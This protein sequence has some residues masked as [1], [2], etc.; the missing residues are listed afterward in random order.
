ML[1]LP[2]LYQK[3]EHTDPENFRLSFPE[4]KMPRP[5]RRSSN[6]VFQCESHPL[7][8]KFSPWVRIKVVLCS[9]HTRLII[10]DPW[11]S[12]NQGNSSLVKVFPSPYTPLLKF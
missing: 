10:Y 9:D 3:R 6:P 11:K 4:D 1:N 8:C 12:T 2:R 5:N 7:A